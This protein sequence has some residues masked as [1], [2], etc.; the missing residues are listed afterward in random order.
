MVIFQLGVLP[1]FNYKKLP[2]NNYSYNSNFIIVSDILSRCN[3]SKNQID[4]INIYLMK[5]LLFFFISILL[6]FNSGYLSAQNY[7]SPQQHQCLKC[8]SNQIYSFFNSVK[9]KE[10]KRLMNPYFIIDTVA[11]KHGVH[12]QF[13]CTDCHSSEYASYPH[14]ATLKL[15]PM[16]SCLD[17]HGGDVSFAKYK[18]EVIEEEFKKSVHYQVS[19]ESF[20]CS[21]CHSQHTYAPTARTSSNV[22]EIVEYS[23]KMCLSCHNDM[24]KYKL[25]SGHE[26]PKLVQIHSWLPNQE[27]HFQH[28]RCIEC[29]TQVVDSLMVSHDILPKGKALRKCVECHS[30]NSRLKAS[31]YKYQNLQKRADSSDY[32]ALFDNESYVIGSHQSPFLKLLSIIIFVLTLTGI[33]IH[34]IFRIIKKK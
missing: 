28:V 2:Y 27:L 12:Q 15:E 3:C 30:S 17:C 5:Y 24:R 1:F 18:F 23:N 8:H 25:V 10:D 33:I 20:N 16:S 19:G 21:K 14:T 34:S 7:D 26:N 11:L 6:L 32:N 22:H 9:D 31:L 29:H 13:D 4:L